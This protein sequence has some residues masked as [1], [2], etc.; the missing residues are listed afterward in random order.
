MR[1]QEVMVQDLRVEVKVEAEVWARVVGK[2]EVEWAVRSPRDRA[3]FAYAPTADTRKAML[4]HSP[5]TR[6]VAPNAVR[7]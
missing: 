4:R 3:V 6:R 1:C 7:Q 5:A 2:A